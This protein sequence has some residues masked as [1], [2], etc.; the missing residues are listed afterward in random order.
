MTAP[1]SVQQ[2]AVEECRP[3]LL[4]VPC[5]V[6]SLALLSLDRFRV[7]RF[8]SDLFRA[9]ELR[10]FGCRHASTQEEV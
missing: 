2:D 8:R 5:E 4:V 9:F 1:H 10:S 7:T 3:F 6:C